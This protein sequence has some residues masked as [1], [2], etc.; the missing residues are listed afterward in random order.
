MRSGD[1]EPPHPRPDHDP[2]GESRGARVTPRR[3]ST[4]AIA[5]TSSGTVPQHPPTA[6]APSSYHA[7][8]PARSRVWV[9]RRASFGARR[10]PT[11]SRGSGRRRAV[12]LAAVAGSAGAARQRTPAVCSSR[13]RPAPPRSRRRGGRIGDRR[14]VADALLVAAA[15]RHPRA[16]L[17][18]RVEQAHDRLGLDDRRDRLDGEQIRLGPSRT[19][20]RG[21]WKATSSS[22]VMP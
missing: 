10:R 19:S 1:A 22:V 8:A 9:L 16:S 5:A 2:L 11:S 20:S 13:R 12:C 4:A 3:R 14:S 15:E 6:V 17:G 21:S 7:A 18:A